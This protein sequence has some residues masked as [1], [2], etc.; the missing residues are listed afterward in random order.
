VSADHGGLTGFDERRGAEIQAVEMRKF[1][2]DRQQD[3]AQKADRYDLEMGA[4]IGTVHGMVHG[5]IHILLLTPTPFDP[6]SLFS[7]LFLW[8]V[9]S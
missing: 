1:A 7:G 2:E 3:R 4:A 6:A 5:N 8:I 9:L